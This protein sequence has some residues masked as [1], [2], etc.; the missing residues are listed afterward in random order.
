MSRRIG[1]IVPVLVLVLACWW[2]PQ[3]S[4]RSA[5]VRP[6]LSALVLPQL[7]E[8]CMVAIGR[9]VRICSS[10]TPRAAMVCGLA[11]VDLLYACP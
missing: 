10:P 9:A 1:L 4:M 2:G 11:L 6:V 8:A 5:A 7:S 3:P